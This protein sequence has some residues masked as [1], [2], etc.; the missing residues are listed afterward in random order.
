[1]GP[2]AGTAFNATVLSYKDR[3]DIGLNIDTAAIDDPELL[4]DLRSRRRSRELA[5]S[6]AAEQPLVGTPTSSCRRA[7]RAPQKRADVEEEVGDLGDDISSRWSSSPRLRSM[8]ASASMITSFSTI[9]LMSRSTL[10]S[11]TIA[12]CNP[13]PGPVLPGRAL[14]VPTVASG[15]ANRVSVSVPRCQTRPSASPSPGPWLGPGHR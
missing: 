15:V 3:L 4:R 6:W 12:P 11:P 13:P 1:M 7:R 10:G 14:P 8:I 2:T 5:A 9:S